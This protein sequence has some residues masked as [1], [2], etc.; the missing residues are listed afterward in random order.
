MVT[1]MAKKQFKTES[2]RIL[3]LMINSIYTHQEIFLREIISNASDAIDKLCYISLTD[4]NVGMNR[5]DFKIKLAVSEP[6]RIISVSD[7]GVGMTQEDLE[8]NLGVIAKSG[9]LNFKS[10]LDKTEE[11]AENI[12]I[13]GQFGVGFYSAFMVA[14]KVT[15]I[16]R[17]YN[18]DKAYK[19]ESEGVDGY[20]IEEYDKE[21]VGTDVIMHIKEDVEESEYTRFLNEMSIGQLVKKYSD[22]IRWPIV[23]D[24][25]EAEE[26]E[27]GE[28]DEDGKPI[29]KQVP[30]KVEMTLNSMVPIWQRPKEEVTKEES[31]DFYMNTFFDYEP[32]VSVIRVNA[33]GM[34]SYKAML[35]VPGK[36]P[37]TFFSSEYEPGLQLYSNGVMIMEHCADVIPDCFRFMR[38]VVDSPD[39]S[40]NI[41]RETLQ[42]S[43][44][45]KMIQKNLEKKIKNEL[46][47]LMDEE[48]DKYNKFYNAFGV[49]LKYGIVGTQEQKDE[50]LKDLLMFYSSKEKELV[51][52]REYKAKMPE[53]QK[54]IYYVCTD[55]IARAD[56]LPQAEQ[57]REKGY[58]ILYMTENVDDFVIKK[59]NNYDDV[60]FCN[61][62]TDDLGLETEEEKNNAEKQEEENKELLDFVK[63][64]LGDEIEAV[65]IS[66]KLKS[67]P[68]Y[69]TSEGEVTIEMEK[70]F[71]GMQNEVAKNIKAK[72]VL[73][74]NANNHAFEALKDAYTNDKDKA[75]KL[76]KILLAQGKLIAG[77]PIENAAEYSALVC[78]MF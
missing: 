2:K 36:T 59:L 1:A 39:F 4:E 50:L 46:M 74:L 26:V 28:M 55:S 30:K 34:V 5:E 51:P 6:D 71:K 23:I 7:N 22:F 54:F 67:Q 60:E 78:E 18:S 12:D 70:Y 42:Q 58:E 27:T 32:P 3:D 44:Q 41:S 20:T 33:E 56:C 76:S 49:Q 24:G 8:N 47:R 73:E 48:P 52:F 14:D 40:L 10:K 21:T 17:A 9:S 43:R 69:L 45:L 77:L 65:K 38:G 75:V 19:W 64:N 11:A 53:N 68:V 62:T 29:T 63:E 66:Y 25:T 13:I 72:L 37:A 15:V 35:F 16:S 31:D 57:I 61:I